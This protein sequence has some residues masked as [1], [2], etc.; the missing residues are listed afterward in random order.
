MNPQQMK[1]I[2]KKKILLQP[3][4]IVRVKNWYLNQKTRI[5]LCKLILKLLTVLILFTLLDRIVSIEIISKYRQNR[6][7]IEHS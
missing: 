4:K 5:F 2:M 7:C 6:K 3:V 1:R